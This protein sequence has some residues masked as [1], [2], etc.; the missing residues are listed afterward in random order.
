[1]MW[2][3][4][5]A[6]D[7]LRDPRITVHSVPSDRM[8]PG[9]DVKLSGRAIEETDPEVRRVYRGVLKARID[10]APDEPH[11]HLFSVDITEAAYMRFGDDRVAL[12]WD[13]RRGFRELRHPDVPEGS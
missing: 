3:S 7:L 2:Q 11:F 6:H 13:E 8:N 12:H 10:W 5:K 9:G 1:M 4:R